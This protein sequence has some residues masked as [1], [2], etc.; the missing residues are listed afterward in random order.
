MGVL[1]AFLFGLAVFFRVEV[2]SALLFRFVFFYLDP[3][4]LG[5]GVL[6]DAC[7]MPGDAYPWLAAS[8]D[9]SV[10]VTWNLAPQYGKCKP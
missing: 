1:D 2:E 6:P 3:E 7:H 9:G 10:S 5:V 8:L 4:R